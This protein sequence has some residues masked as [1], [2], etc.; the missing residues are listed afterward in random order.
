MAVF[1]QFPARDRRQQLL[2][3]GLAELVFAALARRATGLGEGDQVGHVGSCRRRGDGGVLTEKW[4]PPQF[5]GTGTN[6][7]RQGRSEA[8]Q[9]GTEGVSSFHSRWT[10]S[11]DTQKKTTIYKSSK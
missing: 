7:N 2:D 8:S 4:G 11:T 3:A 1:E 6:A 10:P 5:Y 9:V